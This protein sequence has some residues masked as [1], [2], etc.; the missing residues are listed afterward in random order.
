MRRRLVGWAARHPWRLLFAYL[1]ITTALYQ[2]ALRVPLVDPVVVEPLAIDAAIP[3]WP[4][5]AWIYLTYF[6]LMPSFVVASRGRG[7]L[8]AAAMLVVLGNLAIN[9]L[10]PTEVGRVV[11]PD[12]VSW[13]LSRIIAGD[14]PR[15][16]LPSGHVS[17]P[18]ALTALSFIGR[19]RW[20][21]VYAAWALLLTASV[22]TTRQHVLLDAV[23]GLAYGA[24]AAPAVHAW[25]ARGGAVKLE[26]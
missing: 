2:L 20:R 23:A 13:P 25:L 7:A 4:W 22:L 8:L 26:R 19:L 14:T 5:T 11:D 18:T 10:V 17:L 3:L 15:A 21:W 6:A 9:N 1:A 16:A 24:L 12:T